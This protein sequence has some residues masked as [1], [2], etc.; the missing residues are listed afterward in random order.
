MSTKIRKLVAKARV[1]GLVALMSCSLAHADNVAESDRML[2]SV[3]HVLLCVED[4]D[5]FPISILDLDVPQFL[6]V[7][8]R[9]KTISTTKA[10]GENRE[11]KV[12]S[13][14]RDAGRT[15]L[16][17]IELNRA[18]SMLI[19]DDIGRL[20]ATVARDGITISAFGACT[21]ADVK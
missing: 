9:K 20:T 17:G 19:E 2:C 12:A 11:S 15:I 5:C 7:D 6:I 8:I 1:P 10:S 3:S 16:Q 18:Y 4:G 14:S 13:L 21:D